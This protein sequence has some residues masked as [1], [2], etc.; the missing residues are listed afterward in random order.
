MISPDE[1]PGSGPQ[2]PPPPNRK[3]NPNPNSNLSSGASQQRK[4]QEAEPTEPTE[5]DDQYT[6]MSAQSSGST[7][8]RLGRSLTPDLEATGPR[9]VCAYTTSGGLQEELVLVVIKVGSFR[10]HT[11]LRGPSRCESLQRVNN[12]R[13][14]LQ[15]RP[16]AD[17]STRREDFRSKELSLAGDTPKEKGR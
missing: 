4:A 7:F 2:A 13:V 10:W 8:R 5:P 9:D 11:G 15:E 17:P 14:V 12:E 6:H 3:S 16:N 1:T